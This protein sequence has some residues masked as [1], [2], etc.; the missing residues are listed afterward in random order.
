MP[1]FNVLYIISLLLIAPATFADEVT[2]EQAPAFQASSERGKVI[3]DSVCIH[4]H[5]LTHEVS[6]VGCPGLQ[7]VLTRH[8]AAWLD[9]WLT[10]PETFSKT[11]IK[12]KAVVASNPYGL[13]MPTLPEMTHEH[14]R[15]DI[16]EF[17]KTLK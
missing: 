10:S 14:D 7:A 2:E 17:L 5:H 4:C 3:F 9:A 13:V 8:N 12:A 15:L 1:I 6:A 16:I 11:D